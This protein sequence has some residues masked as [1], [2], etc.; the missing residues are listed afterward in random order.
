[1]KRFI[2]IADNT[3]RD[4]IER[5]VAG[6]SIEKSIRLDLTY[7]G[8]CLG[9]TKQQGGSL[10]LRAAVFNQY[11]GRQHNCGAAHKKRYAYSSYAGF[12]F[13]QGR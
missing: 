12:F 9:N 13:R 8:Y 10:V 2:K 1:M 11:H 5:L 6:E 4:E 3:T 7:M